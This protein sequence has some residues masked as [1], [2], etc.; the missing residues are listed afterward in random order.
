MEII[1]KE[2]IDTLGLE[3]DLVNVKPGYA[4]NFLLPRRKAVEATKGNLAQLERERAVIEAR[5]LK[6]RQEAEG[7]AARLAGVTLTIARRVGEENKLFGSVTSSDIAEALAASGIE[8]D[9]KLV[10]LTEPLK[11]IGEYV[12]QVKTGF[13]MTA[14]LTVQV[15]PEDMAPLQE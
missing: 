10:H 4:R 15:V 12:V 13:Q 5:R 1:L 14:P 11:A 7:L 2:N 6:Q 8:L 9:R 3:G